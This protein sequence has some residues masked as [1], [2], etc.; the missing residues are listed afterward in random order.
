[1]ALSVK[2]S[3]IHPCGCERIY[4]SLFLEIFA[5]AQAETNG[6]IEKIAAIINLVFMLKISL[7]KEIVARLEEKGCLV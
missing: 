6:S 1:M 2:L 7:Y 4:A 5:L 3:S